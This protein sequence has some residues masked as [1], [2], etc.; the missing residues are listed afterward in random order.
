VRIFGTSDSSVVSVELLFLEKRKI[1]IVLFN[2]PRVQ[3]IFFQV[4]LVKT[5][6]ITFGMKI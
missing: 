5:L 4:I 3:N 2:D 1:V 6:G